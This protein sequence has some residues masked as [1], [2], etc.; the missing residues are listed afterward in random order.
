MISLRIA[1]PLVMLLVLGW[2]GAASAGLSL[3]WE[4]QK[5]AFRYD[6]EEVRVETLAERLERDRGSLVLFDVRSGEEYAVSRIRGAIR[7]DP[8]LSAEAFMAGHGD[9]LR[10]RDLDRKSVV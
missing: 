9:R 8:G 4:E 6:V 1:P 10:G 2:A 7:L 5:V 3:W